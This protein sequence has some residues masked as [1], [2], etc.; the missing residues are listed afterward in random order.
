MPTSATVQALEQAADGLAYPSETD[1]P[2]TAF[3]WPTAKG[4]PTGAAVRRW[5]KHKARAPVEEEALDEFFAPLVGEQDWYGDQERATAAKYR[6]LLDV[7]KHYLKG[8]KVVRVGGRTKAVYVV[9]T[10][11][12]GGWA[13]L[14]TTA[15]ET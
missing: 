13:G 12:E 1:A 2:W 8:A 15:V 4:D 9:G 7:V 14:K 11:N 10:A 3:A 5:G 6:A